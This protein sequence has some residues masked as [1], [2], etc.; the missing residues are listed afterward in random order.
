MTTDHELDKI[1]QQR[2]VE[3]T[4]AEIELLKASIG[5]L[6]ENRNDISKK[7]DLHKRK[8]ELQLDNMEVVN[9]QFKY[10]TL[11][12]YQ[13][14]ERELTQVSWDMKDKFEYQKYLEQLDASIETHQKQI[15]SLQKKLKE[16]K[17]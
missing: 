13:E 10:Q 4:A 11:D 16:E 7:R 6:L 17:K 14:I 8:I 1:A 2:D 12:E 5:N 3:N 15:E 9:P